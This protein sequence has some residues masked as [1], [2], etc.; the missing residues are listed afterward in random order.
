MDKPVDVGVRA[1]RVP[2]PE[3]LAAAR[4]KG[5]AT[6]ATPTTKR[7]QDALS[8][9]APTQRAQVEKIAVSCPPRHLG[10][11]LRTVL[12]KESLP[13][14]VK[15]M[16]FHCVGWENARFEVASCTARGCPLWA[17]RPVGPEGDDNCQESDD[18]CD[19]HG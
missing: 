17:Y 5:L 13:E 18:G 15:C 19:V 9:V 2:D 3:Q 11:Y 12:G 10:R 4:F 16:C 7:I 8:G 6:L 14:A 1:K